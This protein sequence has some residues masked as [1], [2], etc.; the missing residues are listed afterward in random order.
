MFPF[1]WNR[2]NVWWFLYRGTQKYTSFKSTLDIKLLSLS[3]PL[4]LSLSEDPLTD[5]NLPFWSENWRWMNTSWLI[6]LDS[7]F[8]IW[9]WCGTLSWNGSSYKSINPDTHSNI[10]GSLLRIFQ[11]S[12]KYCS[13]P[14]TEN[15][16]ISPFRRR[17][18]TRECTC[19]N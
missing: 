1:Y 18:T 11:F 6:N 4:S 16:P 2:R 19:F 10:F 8:D 15:F 3:P 13:L 12:K 7:C 5:A 9:A 14:A 17:C